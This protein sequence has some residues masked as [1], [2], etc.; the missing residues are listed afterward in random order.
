VSS[1]VLPGI[2][3][4]MRLYFC[5]EWGNPSSVYKFGSNLKGV[6]ESA[7]AWVAALIGAQSRG[8]SLHVQR[9]GQQR[10]EA[11]LLKGMIRHVSLDGL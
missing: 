6:I 4:A 5:E 2:F 11:H 9:S 8:I 7:R 10:F 1:P 3:E